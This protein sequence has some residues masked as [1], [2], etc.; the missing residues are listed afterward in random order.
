MSATRTDDL[1]EQALARFSHIAKSFGTD[2]LPVLMSS[3]RPAAVRQALRRRDRNFLRASKWRDA[4]P[5]LPIATTQ[6]PAIEQH[7][8]ACP[9][10]GPKGFDQ[11]RVEEYVPYTA[12]MAPPTSEVA[13]GIAHGQLAVPPQR[14][15]EASEGAGGVASQPPAPPATEGT[16]DG[17]RRLTIR[18]AAIYGAQAK[19]TRLQAAWR[20]Y[21][22]RHR[23]MLDASHA[24]DLLRRIGPVMPQALRARIEEDMK[25]EPGWDAMDLDD[26]TMV[27]DHA[28]RQALREALAMRASLLEV[29]AGKC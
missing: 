1:P 4:L 21:A 16:G 10:S 2:A 7:G 22:A 29:A 28:M 27:L 5:S 26:K 15:A 3:L 12:P 6:A 19:A 13:A 23:K 24:R 20:G 9:P 11:S 18:E 14:S 8:Y 17:T 25:R